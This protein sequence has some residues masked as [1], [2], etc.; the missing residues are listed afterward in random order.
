MQR[1]GLKS[2][3]DQRLKIFDQRESV[4]LAINYGMFAQKMARAS[5]NWLF[6]KHSRSI[7]SIV[8]LPNT[9]H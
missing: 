5:L 4:M 7:R 8:A 3:L 6:H 9:I 1:R 2:V